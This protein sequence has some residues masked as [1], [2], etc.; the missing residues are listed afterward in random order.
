M[1]RASTIALALGLL[2]ATI[3]LSSSAVAADATPLWVK[4]VRNYAGGISG[5]VQIGRAHV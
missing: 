3:A 4:H 5:G 1:R 2:T